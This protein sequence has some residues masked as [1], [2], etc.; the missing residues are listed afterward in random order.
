MT[1]E[2]HGSDINWQVFAETE[3]SHNVAIEGEVMGSELSR[4]FGVTVSSNCEAST[5]EISINQLPSSFTQV[6]WNF[7]DGQTMS[8]EKVTKLFSQPGSY[9]FELAL[10]AAA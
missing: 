7:E 6:N 4:N 9:D 3:A 2:H 5:C 1:K 8:G 10:Q